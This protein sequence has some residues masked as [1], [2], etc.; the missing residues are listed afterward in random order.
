MIGKFRKAGIAAVG[1]WRRA[2]SFGGVALAGNSGGAGHASGSGSHESGR[3]GQQGATG[4]STTRNCINL[5]IDLLSGDSAGSGGS[6]GIAGQDAAV[7][8]ACDA[9]A[10]GTT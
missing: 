3:G 5:G 10:N 7:A 1:G 6:S 4:G 2:S 8:A 9:S